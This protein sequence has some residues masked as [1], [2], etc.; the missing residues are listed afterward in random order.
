MCSSSKKRH[1]PCLKLWI[2]KIGF[3]GPK[4]FFQEKLVMR[5]LSTHKSSYFIIGFSSQLKMNENSEN[6]SECIPKA[7][8]SN[9][10]KIYFCLAWHDTVNISN[11]CVTDIYLFVSITNDVFIE[12]KV[13]TLSE[14]FT[15]SCHDM[16]KKNCGQWDLN[17]QSLAWKTNALSTTLW[18]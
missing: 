14:I 3:F 11:T 6:R 2:L 8:S 15:V 5:H 4:I 9:P 18:V 7:R 13:I 10:H 17:S 1:I 16:L 12:S